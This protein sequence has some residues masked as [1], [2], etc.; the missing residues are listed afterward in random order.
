MNSIDLSPLYRNSVGFDRIASMLDSA[1]H[2]DTV[3]GYPPYDIEVREENRY[4]VTLAVAGFKRE[5]LEIYVEQG[6]LTV[7]GKKDEAKEKKLLHNG[8][9]TRNFERRFNLADY[10]EVSSANLDNGLLTIELFKEVPEAMKP[11]NIEIRQSTP[12]LEHQGDAS[13]DAEGKAA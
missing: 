4:A 1:L 10:V 2:S 6:V 3:S 5:E 8:I 12:A 11:K 7:R 9:A 13:N